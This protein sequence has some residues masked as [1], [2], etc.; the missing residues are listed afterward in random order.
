MMLALNTSKI[1]IRILVHRVNF[2]NFRVGKGEGEEE[3]TEAGAN[4]KEDCKDIQQLQKENNA[5]CQYYGLLQ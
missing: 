4:R 3:Q 5:G 2:C 1:I